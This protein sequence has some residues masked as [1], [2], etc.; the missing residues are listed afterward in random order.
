M[1]DEKTIVETITEDLAEA[2]KAVV[3]E[4]KSIAAEVTDAVESAAT[5]DEGVVPPKDDAS[6]ADGNKAPR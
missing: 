6:L 2:A 5:C 1:G 3:A 4:V